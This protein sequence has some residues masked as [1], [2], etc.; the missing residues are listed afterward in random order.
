MQI[1]TVGNQK[2][3]VGKSTFSVHL[4]FRAAELGYRVLLIDVDEGDLSEVFPEIEEN[5]GTDYLK[6][7][8]LFTG[9][10]KGRQPRQV[11]EKIALIEADVDVLDVDDMPLET[12]EQPRLSLA[13]LNGN[14]DFC[15][16][17]TPPNLQRR[18]LGALVASHAVVSPFNI[19][20]FSFA[21][22]PKLQ[23]TIAGVK[24]QYNPNLN[25]LGFLANMVNS[26]SVNEVEALPELREAYG[27]LIFDEAIIA[28]ACVATALAQGH[29]VWHRARSGNQR[30]SAKE[31]RRACDA[32]L[33]RLGF[34]LMEPLS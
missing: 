12:I 16:I 26:K 21:R 24:S 33:T 13:Q 4:A 1:L 7:S 9:E 14:Y 5:D 18:M 8:H 28:R 17:D 27:E 3:G 15:I 19:S 25:H 22:M 31:M 34:K 10:I 32:V 29:A 23:A 6:A 30:A 20:P 2:G 11:Y